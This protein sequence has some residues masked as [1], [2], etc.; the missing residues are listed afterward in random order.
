MSSNLL[1]CRDVGC[2]SESRIKLGAP[3]VQDL[4]VNSV[5]FS[6]LMGGDS[7]HLKQDR[8]H[9]TEG[10]Y[11]SIG[12]GLENSIRSACHVFRTLYFT[13]ARN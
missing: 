3:C 7:C 12:D 8:K 2:E 6:N 9:R 4:A 13:I 5:Q 10:R 11:S 1:I